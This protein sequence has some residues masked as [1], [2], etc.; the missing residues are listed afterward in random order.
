MVRYHPDS[1][2][3]KKCLAFTWHCALWSPVLVFFFAVTGP[4]QFEV[5]KLNVDMVTCNGC[6]GY[7]TVDVTVLLPRVR[8]C[9]CVK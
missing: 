9:A 2:F 8:V 6:N 3:L 5:V 4:L 1:L 7:V